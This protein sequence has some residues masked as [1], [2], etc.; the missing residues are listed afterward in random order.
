[1]RVPFTF[2]P[3]A[4][5][6]A[7]PPGRVDIGPIVAALDAGERVVRGPGTAARFDEERV[8]AELRD[9]VRAVVL[10]YV[11]Y[12]L[13]EDANGESLYYDLVRGPILEWA[14]DR[15]VRLV[16]VSG[17]D[18][19]LLN[20]PSSLDHR[21]PADLD[22]LRTTAASRDVTE[23][24]VVL[25][26]LGRGLPPDVAE[27]T[28]IVHPAPVPAPPELVAEVAATLGA[29]RIHN[30]PGRADLIEDWVPERAR[31]EFDLTVRVAAFPVLEPGQPVVDYATPL[32]AMFPDDVV[33]VLHGDWVDVVAPDQNKALAAR[34][35]VYGDA[36]LSLFTVGD[37]AN[38][39]VRQLIDRLA[40][41]M[42]ETSW[43]LPQPPPQPR[44]VPFDV[45]RTIAALAPW[46]L[47][48]S[49]VVLGGAGALRYRS[50]V[51]A[52]AA[53]EVVALRAE[54]ASAM[55]AIAELGARVL[56]LE[57]GGAHA[58]AAERH[59]TARLLYDQALTSEAMVQ[60]RRVAE[61]GLELLTEGEAD[62]EASAE[63]GPM[64]AV[65]ARKAKKKPRKADRKFPPAPRGVW[66]KA[67]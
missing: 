18:V 32:G 29:G 47:V 54:G 66:R 37:G 38:S 59:A 46:T 1:V 49:A 13:Y 2:V 67:R 19:T 6:A 21:L 11:H 4:P 22:E 14:L 20:S 41:L 64:P 10:P 55:A 36:D 51:R 24:M 34:A 9:D 8:R 52:A 23:R 65:R 5:A 7:Q 17:V 35:F 58:G 39:L 63:A 60:V 48:G 31:E 62:T 12:D 28:E 56:S 25:A 40:M 3:A 33:L 53:A 44:P 27:R 16:L 61:E 43:G 15:D 26:R 57:E 45:A 30:A 50:R 42:A